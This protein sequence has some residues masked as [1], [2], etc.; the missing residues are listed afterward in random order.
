MPGPA[1]PLAVAG[2]EALGGIAASAWNVREARRN[3]AF[4]ERMSSTAWQREV[5][6][7]K[8]AGINPMVKFGSGASTPA[9]DRAQVENPVRGA[10]S[11][12][13]Q[14]RLMKAQAANL[15]SQTNL[16]VQQR[17]IMHQ[18]LQHWLPEDWNLAQ[19][20]ANAEIEMMT[21]SARAAKAKALLDEA[22]RTGA[23]NQ[24]ELEELIGQ[25]GPWV[26]AFLNLIRG[27][28]RPQ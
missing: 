7:M 3:R 15:E 21:S 10:A 8:K 23:L 17:D 19:D 5:A 11:T 20:K 12:A 26:R 25:A 1:L 18:R 2:I 6:D 27:F 22:A 14:V 16:N 24:Q 13:L 4:Q 28:R 9:G